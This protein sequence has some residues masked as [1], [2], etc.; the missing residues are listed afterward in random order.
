MSGESLVWRVLPLLPRQAAA[1]LRVEEVELRRVEPQLRL[2]PAPDLARRL[3]PSDD[4]ALRRAGD[5]SRPG[6]LG[7]LA[8]LLGLDRRLL[9]L[10]I[11]VHLGPERL[12]EID[13]RLERR[14]PVADVAR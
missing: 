2:R 5:L 11:R 4:L 8:E 6:V 10:E 1:V 13:R 9:D 14:A 12:D 3:Q 7:Q